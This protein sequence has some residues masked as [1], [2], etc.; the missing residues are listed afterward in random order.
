METRSTVADEGS[1]DATLAGA[2]TTETAQHSE[3]LLFS[4]TAYLGSHLADVAQNVM[5]DVNGSWFLGDFDSAQFS[6]DF[7]NCIQ[8]L[9]G[10][11]SPKVHDTTNF[12]LNQ[13]FFKD[14]QF[15]DNIIVADNHYKAVGQLFPKG[16][17]VITKIAKLPKPRA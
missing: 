1:P 13:T 16:P 2:A 17:K 10:G 15:E 14:K 9:H 4:A 3:P 8:I 12:E 11:Y 6:I 7:H 5:V